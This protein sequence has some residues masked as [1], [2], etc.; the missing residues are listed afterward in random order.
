MKKVSKVS[1]EKVMGSRAEAVGIEII[2]S[3]CVQ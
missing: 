1:I 3:R 2:D